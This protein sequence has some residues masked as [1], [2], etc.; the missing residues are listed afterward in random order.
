MASPTFS[1]VETG[2]FEAAAEIDIGG[3]EYIIDIDVKEMVEVESV[4]FASGTLIRTVR[5]DV[6]VEDLSVGDLVV[7]AT[8]ERR[9]IRWLGHRTVDC[10]RHENQQ[11]VLPVR[12]SAG[13][14]GPGRPERD[15]Y[16]SP[17]HSVCVTVLDEVLIPASTLINGATVAQVEVD[18][19]TYWHVELDSH[20]ILV[21][22]GLPAESFNDVGNRAF[23]VESQMVAL[24]VLPDAAANAMEATCR[25]FVDGGAVVDVVRERMRR[26]A[27]AL[28]WSFSSAP[29]G[30]LHVVA[31][32]ARIEPDASGL[33]A[34]FVVPA[35][36]REVWLVSDASIPYDLGLNDDK[37]TLGVCVA[38]VSASDGLDVQRTLDLDDQLHEGFYSQEGTSL[39]WTNGRARLPASLWAD[40]RAVFFLRVDL[41]MTSPPRWVAPSHPAAA[42]RLLQASA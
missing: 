16:V 39:H 6:A 22:N 40:C 35:S 36:A 37:R 42:A 34:R 2:T 30:G 1:I 20:D 23:F 33:H 10:R 7:T 28:D 21:A 12:I 32:G 15:L 11:A 13:A 25:P 18:E 29:L 27:Q 38:A 17:G 19:V 4:C 41:A 3:K 31:D 9:P 26:R 14:F 5:G 24:D 8:D